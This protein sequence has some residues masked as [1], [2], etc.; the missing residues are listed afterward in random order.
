MLQLLYQEGCSELI[1]VTQ[2]HSY[3]YHTKL[4]NSSSAMYPHSSLHISHSS[5][6]GKAS[7]QAVQLVADL[8][9]KRRC[10]LPPAVVS[11]LLV[12]RFQAVTPTSQGGEGAGRA[13][14]PGGKSK[15]WWG[16]TWRDVM[17]AG[18]SCGRMSVKV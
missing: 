17:L 7:L 9:R 2:S 12:L 8:V 14:A 18:L 13:G 6:Q 5:L 15:V 10:S 11:C 16:V 4:I 3:T 1:T